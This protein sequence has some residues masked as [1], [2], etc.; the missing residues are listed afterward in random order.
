MNGRDA[1]LPVS[2]L[3]VVQRSKV[4]F[5]VS[6][7]FDAPSRDRGTGALTACLQITAVTCRHGNDRVLTAVHV[8][9]EKYVLIYTSAVSAIFIFRYLEC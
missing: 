1:D 3:S 2:V 7:T 4:P 8:G 6:G 9:R 5:Q